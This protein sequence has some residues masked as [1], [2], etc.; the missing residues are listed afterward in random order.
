MIESF[1][2]NEQLPSLNDYINILKSPRGQAAGARF[3]RQVDQ[4]CI[5]YI[6]PHRQRLT[7][8]CNGKVQ[9]HFEWHEKSRRRDVDNVYSAKKY[10]LDALQKCGVLANDNPAHVAHVS[11]SVTYGTTDYVIVFICPVETER[12]Q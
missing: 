1:T 7:K 2:I 6:L 11:D 8:C 3:K 10:I 12:V 4:L 9:I 5:S